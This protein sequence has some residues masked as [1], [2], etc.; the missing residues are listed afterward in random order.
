MV[1]GHIQIRAKRI[2]QHNHASF[3]S[4][5]DWGLQRDL[6]NLATIADYLKSFVAP[7]KAHLEFANRIIVS[8]SN[9]GS[10]ESWDK[11][12]NTHVDKSAM[13]VHSAGADILV[14][15]IEECEH[16]HEPSAQFRPD[17]SI[18]LQGAWRG[19]SG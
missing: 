6:P 7:T 4:H 15:S 13:P 14:S 5:V 1:I 17:L 9:G 11:E 12:N 10:I 8:M 18:P 19:V 3:P 16:F 2:P